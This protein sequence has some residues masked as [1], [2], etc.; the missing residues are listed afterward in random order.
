MIILRRPLFVACLAIA[1]LAALWLGIKEP[2][3]GGAAAAD[4]AGQTPQENEYVK[5][6]GHVYRTETRESYGREM[7]VFYLNSV[8]ILERDSSPVNISYPSDLICESTQTNRPLLGS[9]ITITG[10][11]SYYAAATNEG[12]FDSSGYYRVLGIGCRLRNAEI[13]ESSEEYSVIQ[14]GLYRLRSFWKGRLYSCFPQKEASILSTMLLGDKTELDSS[15]KALYK[16]NGIVHILSI[17]GLHITLIGMGIYQMLRKAGLPVI[18]SAIVGGVILMLYGVMTGLG[19]SA[20][21]AIGMYLIRMLGECLGRTYDMLTAMG[22]MGAFMLLRQPEYLRHSGFLLSFGSICAIGILLPAI[23]G[24]WN[25]GDAGKE[26]VKHKNKTRLLYQWLTESRRKARKSCKPAEGKGKACQCKLAES[27]RKARKSGKPAESMGQ[28]QQ[29]PKMIE[30]L[31]NKFQP[32]KLSAKIKNGIH[33]SFLAGMSITLFTLPVHLCFYYEIPVYSVFLNMLVLPFMGIVMTVGLAVMLIPWAG[34]LSH[35]VVLFL[36]CYESLCKFFDRLPFHT[37]TPGH[38]KGWQIVLFYIFLAASAAVG[39]YLVKKGKRRLISNGVSGILLLFAVFFLGARIP[40]GLSISF[41]DVG[42]GDCILV[43][44]DRGEAYL[45]DGGSSD[46]PGVGSFI[47]APFLKYHGIQHLDA[48][49]VSHPDSDH[50]SGILE[51]M[52]QENECGIYIDRLILPGMGEGASEDMSQLLTAAQYPGGPQISHMNSGAYWESGQT[53]FLCLH[54]PRGFQ[55]RDTNAYSQCFLVQYGDFSLLLTGDVEAEG[56]EA[57]YEE[58]VS[59]NIRNITVLKTAHH[60]SRNS[61]SG[62]FLNQINPELAIISCGQDNSYGHPH[63]ELLE[64]LSDAGCVI[65]STPEEGAIG[66]QIRNGKVRISG[67]KGTG[68]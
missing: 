42:Q 29:I 44:T 49:F 60:G 52:E 15:V 64:R 21:R 20:C 27:R 66:I 28:V 25:G 61:T 5:V 22:I 34:F 13:L 35:V 36:S 32:D 31:R 8:I 10:Q 46:K 56:E 6:S 59:R 54:P 58:L 24:I 53:R 12:E 19:I 62:E 37:W 47:I 63:K 40:L 18:L 4:N 14:E 1:A 30:N 50:I 16:R 51:L 26:K 33:Q 9:K 65:I 68:M 48:V 57:L 41:L 17:S 39:R 11:I 3:P 38:P 45:V 67:F 23:T 7:L 2:R 43:Q 55:T